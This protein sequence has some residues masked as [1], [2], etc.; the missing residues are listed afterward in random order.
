MFQASRPVAFLDY[1]RVP[2]QVRPAR[3]TGSAHA[4]TPLTRPSVAAMP[5][6]AGRAGRSL[7]WLGRAAAPP[8]S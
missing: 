7:L 5:G 6:R 4:R 2:Y 3:R 8:D 1:F